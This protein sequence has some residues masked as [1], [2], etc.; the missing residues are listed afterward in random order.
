MT[1][2]VERDFDLEVLPFERERY[3][4]KLPRLSRNPSIIAGVVYDDVG[5]PAPSRIVRIYSRST[6]AMLGQCVTDLAGA[7]E[8]A[9]GYVG[10]V[11]RIVLDDEA[12]LLHN[13]LIDRIDLP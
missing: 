10:E 3:P 2:V 5:Q 13:D 1:Y 8:I 11:Q 12:G 6:G 9:V 7:Y 4:F